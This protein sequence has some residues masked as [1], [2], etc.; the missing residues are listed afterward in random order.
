LRLTNSKKLFSQEGRETAQPSFPTPQPNRSALSSVSVASA[1][2]NHVLSNK[3]LQPRNV[4]HRLDFDSSALTNKMDNQ[5][6]IE[7]R[8]AKPKIVK[9]VQDQGNIFFSQQ[10]TFANSSQKRSRRDV[11]S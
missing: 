8:R 6:R 4:T 1:F 3:L 5:F 9:N 7:N 10:A 2:H 11:S